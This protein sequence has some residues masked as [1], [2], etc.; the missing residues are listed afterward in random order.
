MSLLS[1]FLSMLSTR[2][3]L[4]YN[5]AMQKFGVLADLGLLD[6]LHSNFGRCLKFVM[7]HR[8]FILNVCA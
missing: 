8:I 1:S 3:F 4:D 5:G 2:V 7:A 6:N